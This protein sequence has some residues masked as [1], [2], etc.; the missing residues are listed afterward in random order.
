[1]EL[2]EKNALQWAGKKQHISLAP[3]QEIPQQ[4]ALPLI[5]VIT[6]CRN[7]EKTIRRCIESVLTQTYPHFEY[8]IQDGVSTDRTLNIISEYDDPRIKLVSE[9]DS[10]GSHAY[11]KAL[12]RCSGDIITLCWSDEE[13]LPHAIQ[14]GAENMDLNPEAA[15]IYGDVYSTDIHGKIDEN[16]QPAPAW[17]L[18]KFICW[19][20]M[21]NYC[22]SFM[23]RQALQDSGFFEFTGSFIDAGKTSLEDANCIMYD[24]FTL[25]ALKYPILHVPGYVGKFS[26]HGAQLSST[27]KVIFGMI[28]GLL[29]SIDNICDNPSTPVDIRSLRHR[30][31][32]GIH[33][34][35]INTLLMNAKSYDDAKTMLRASLQYEPDKVFLEKVCRESCDHLLN[36]EEFSHAMEF[37]SIIE[38]S[39]RLF[40][41]FGCIQAE[42]YLEA[43]FIDKARESLRKELSLSV[44]QTKAQTLHTKLN[45]HLE[46]QQSLENDLS[47]LPQGSKKQFVSQLLYFTSLTEHKNQKRFGQIMNVGVSSQSFIDTISILENSVR[48]PGFLISVRDN[49]P[50]ACP[51]I[52]KTLTA[53]LYLAVENG[54]DELAKRITEVLAEYFSK[55]D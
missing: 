34:A 7:S 43:G 9:P 27:P 50:D 37:L 3:S 36:V 41:N 54:A 33:L 51:L 10:G 32:A 11:F 52:E 13:L 18:E 28:P 42:A 40:P 8:I 21:T 44:D 6:I 47:K 53:Y 2:E 4:E 26:V 24:Y 22:A 12:R 23:R 48:T 15:A 5:S 16:C 31:Y 45:D 17:D 55:T 14:W 35:M 49:L 30:A 19:E 38:S 39:G 1:M 25:P 29:R 46:M 20:M